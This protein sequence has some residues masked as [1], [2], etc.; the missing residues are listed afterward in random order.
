MALCPPPLLVPLSLGFCSFSFFMDTQPRD[1]AS[2]L[3]PGLQGP[4]AGG[5]DTPQGRRAP[6]PP[7]RAALPP[8]Q[9]LS[10]LT[11]TPLSSGPRGRRPRQAAWGAA[12][13][14]A[15]RWSGSPERAVS[16]PEVLNFTLCG[17]SSPVGRASARLP[18]GDQG[19]R[20]S[21]ECW[22]PRPFCSPPL[23]AAPVCPGSAST[24]SRPSP[25][26]LSM[27]LLG[28]DEVPSG[29]QADLDIPCATSLS[30]PP[31]ILLGRGMAGGDAA[32]N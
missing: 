11:P 19:T 28:L 5:P 26:A 29:P 21:D 31:L 10:P 25:L 18:V 13:P 8:L 15:G 32:R 24:S 2:F 9:V 4:G 17:F 22:A 12:A 3:L 14:P 16:P 27:P 6:D 23:R 20:I 1:C 30:S 7:T